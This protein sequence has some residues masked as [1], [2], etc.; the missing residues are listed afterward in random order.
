MVGGSR[1]I[2]HALHIVIVIVIVIDASSQMVGAFCSELA[3]TCILNV[4]K[5][6]NCA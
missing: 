4:R 5:A 3:R 2:Q 1:V 6:H